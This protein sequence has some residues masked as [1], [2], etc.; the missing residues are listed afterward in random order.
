MIITGYPGTGKTSTILCIARNIYGKNYKDAIIELNASDNRG[1]DTINNS[2]IHFCRKKVTL[3][4]NLPKLII[5]DEAD[6]ITSKAQN[7]LINL[8]DKYNN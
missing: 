1:L 8:M 6:N 2:I 3:P 5:L 4:D 7:T